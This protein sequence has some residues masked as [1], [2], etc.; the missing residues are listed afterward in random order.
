MLKRRLA[1]F[2]NPFFLTILIFV[3]QLGLFLWITLRP[4]SVAPSGRNYYI[5]NGQGAYAAYIRQAKEG[6]W[7]L[8]NPYTTRPNPAVYMHLFF[9][10]VGKMAQI[11]S[12]D[13]ITAYMMTRIGTGLLLFMATYWFIITVLPTNFQ[14]LAV[15]FSLGLEPGPLLS[16][17]KNIRSI[18][19]APPAI[20]SYFPQELALR[21]FGIPHHVL[22]EALGLLLLGYVFLYIKRA[23]W[24]RLIVIGLLA[25]LGTLVMPAYNGSLAI[26]VFV[27]LFL[28]SIYEKQ[29]KKI[30]PAL[31]I[32]VVCLSAVGIF[33]KLQMD[34]STLWKYFNIDEKRW[35]TDSFLLVNYFSSLLL[36]IPAV[37]F[38][39]VSAPRV[40][41]R[42][43]STVQMLT[44]LTTT[45]IVGPLLYI[46]L[47]HFNIFPLANFRLVD[48]YAYVPAGILAAIGVWEIAQAFSKRAAALA[49]ALMLTA[50]M[51]LTFSFTD[52][53]FI[54]QQHIWTNVYPLNQEWDAIQYLSTIPKNSSVM[55]MK[56]FG[57]II[58]AYATVRVFL[59]ET[60]G[61]LDW[62]QRYQIAVRFYSGQL[63]DNEARSILGRENISYVYWGQDEKKFF[64]AEAL[65]PNVLVP[66]FQ[67]PAVTVFR[68]K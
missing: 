46:P 66:V 58:P 55:V 33:T 27:A 36:Y 32:V 31:I 8:Y 29:T 28:W 62:E 50:S 64:N 39:W 16:A 47:T 3:L 43:S 11:F 57:E 19:S 20:F 25:I 35:V 37:A 67:N 60:P 51:F 18:D 21:H 68:V 24:L 30:L 41:H 48:G 34:S 63:K 13:P 54:G 45:W 52:Q 14:L 65:Y 10:S 38:L 42:M 26:T 61:E 1:F 6:A 2:N 7:K 12:I 4:F 17:I 56:Y 22:A 15:F 23:S 9:V 44:V 40:W 5:L 53:T 49:V 59:G